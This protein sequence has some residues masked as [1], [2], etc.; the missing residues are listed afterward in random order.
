MCVKAEENSLGWYV[1]HHIEP[2]IVAV[3]I[4][5]TVPSE[6]STQPKECKQQDNEERLNNWRGKTIYGQYFRKIEGKY[7]SNTWRWLRKSYLKGFAE[8]LI[9]SA[10]EQALRTNYVKLHIYK[11]GESPLCRMC[12]VEKE[13]VSHIVTECKVLAQKEQFIGNYAKNM[14]S[15]ERISGTS[16]SQIELLRTKGRRFCGILQSG[17]ITRLKLDD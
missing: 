2:L 14:T 10:Q 17:V 15:K 12:R 4:S 6:N 16:M 13:T 9:C 8:V 7:K 3:R 1:K 5:N 11:T